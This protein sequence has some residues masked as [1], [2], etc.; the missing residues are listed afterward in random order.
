MY[1]GFLHHEIA[2]G[3][4]SR[5]T[6]DGDLMVFKRYFGQL[7]SDE[8][9]EDLRPESAA[10][11]STQDTQKGFNDNSLGLYFLDGANE[12]VRC[13]T[14]DFDGHGEQQ[15]IRKKVDVFVRLAR[16]H[17]RQQVDD[18]WSE[19]RFEIGTCQTNPRQLE[20]PVKRKRV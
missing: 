16:L 15:E 14:V 3:Q 20:A 19:V 4:H 9:I 11:L 6:H 17:T 2:L 1:A 5:Q 10:H 7:P 18:N 8:V 12:I 13:E